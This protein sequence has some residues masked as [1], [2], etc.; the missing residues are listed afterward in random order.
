MD[1][2]IIEIVKVFNATSHS[3]IKR[4]HL[5][6]C[7]IIYGIFLC[8]NQWS[9]LKK[10]L[11]DNVNLLT[12]EQFG[13]QDVLLRF[14]HIYENGEDPVLSKPVTFSLRVRQWPGIGL[15][16]IACSQTFIFLTAVNSNCTFVL[17]LK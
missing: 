2:K 6:L 3:I 4:Q 16:D 12:L 14:E 15:L 11:P 1:P 8:R 17:S 9:G 10:A 7:I 5:L 13:P